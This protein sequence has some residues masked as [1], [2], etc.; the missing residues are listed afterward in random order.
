MLVS[1]RG[2]A[3]LMMVGV[4]S[5]A[6]TSSSLA[7][8][9]E[10]EKPISA[11]PA[12]NVTTNSATTNRSGRE[13]D[14]QAGHVEIEG[15][16]NRLSL[17]NGVRLTIN[18]YQVTAGQLTLERTARGIKVA[19]DGTVAFCP[20]SSPP[21]TVGF[22]DATVAPPTDLILRNAQFKAFGVPFFWLPVFWL[23][24]PNRFGVM[25]PKLSYRGTDGA[26]VG[27]GLHVPLSKRAEPSPEYLD[28]SLG[29][30]LFSGVDL[31]AQLVTA[32]T[33]TNLRWDFL[34]HS[35]VEVD[36]QGNRSIGESSAVAWR[37][38]TVRGSRARTGF[39]SFESSSRVF[40]HNRVEA[41]RADGQSLVSFGV[42]TTSLRGL[43]LRQAGLWGPSTRFAV[44]SAISDVGQVDSSTSLFGLSPGTEGAQGLALHR[45]SIRFDSRPG[46]LAVRTSAVE[47]W[48]VG[49]GELRSL[50]SALFGAEGRIALPLIR[51]FTLAGTSA[52][53]WIE[54]EIVATGSL[55]SR[56]NFAPSGVFADVSHDVS[57][58]RYSPVA[59]GRTT[60]IQAGLLNVVGQSRG[61]TV[62]SLLLRVGWVHDWNGEHRVAAAKWLSSIQWLAIGG[63]VGAER[64]SL[65][66][67]D[68]WTTS[69]RGRLGRLDRL[70]IAVR[71]EGR[72]ATEPLAARWLL[73]EGFSPWLSRWYSIP[74]WTMAP[75][76]DAA[77]GEQLAVTYG[78]TTDLD[79]EALLA[80]R[81]GA[82][83]RHPCGCLAAS[84]MTGWRVGRGGWD[85]TLM[86]DLMP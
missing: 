16:F 21:V 58:P 68:A 60:S 1:C 35:L 18:R 17:S 75:Q 82:A 45:S 32:N 40:D 73:D 53:H 27:S 48:S 62:S 77:L 15:P 9:D 14:I 55:E 61:T 69:V 47:S 74:G 11:A 50:S 28:L 7:S 33:L 52:S 41:S 81:A 64:G 30:Y 12:N 6:A 46:P 4:A 36:A 8:A 72:S 51:N 42:Q 38:D 25:P 79:R 56:S 80:Q 39:V 34:R 43:S 37:V 59:R 26:F 24:S 57:G 13:L 23:R 20:C 84:A 5:V 70:S 85:V 54:P 66:S 44:G 65:G 76:V 3:W 83:Y 49:S 71:V 86:V 67:P 78:M 19:G 2:Q 22:S 63:T 31:G 10:S 29:G